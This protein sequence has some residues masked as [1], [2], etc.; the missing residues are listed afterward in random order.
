MLAPEAVEG[1]IAIGQPQIADIIVQAM[2]MLWTPYL[3]ER[4][5][6]E[7][8][9]ELLAPECFRK[10]DE[11]FFALIGTESGGSRAAADRYAAGL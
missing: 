11:R 2:A 9:L 1:F 10:L 3:R 4:E 7:A 6:R 8:A 5:L